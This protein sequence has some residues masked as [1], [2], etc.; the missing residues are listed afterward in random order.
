M[1]DNRLLRA[2]RPGNRPRFGDRDR[3][4]S[5]DVLVHCATVSEWRA[6]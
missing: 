2:V 5:P 4:R 1:V 3:H 6:R